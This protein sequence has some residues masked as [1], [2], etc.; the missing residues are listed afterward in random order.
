MIGNIQTD[1]SDVMAQATKFTAEC[2]GQSMA[3]YLSEAG[4]SVWTAQIGKPGVTCVP[5]FAL[6]PPTAEVFTENGS[7]LICKYF[8]GRMHCN[9]ILRS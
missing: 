1:W 8:F 7:S 4:V 9:L 6:L 3:T 2:Y 5:K